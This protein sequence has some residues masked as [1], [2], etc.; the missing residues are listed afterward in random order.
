MG[1]LNADI[2]LA[3]YEMAVFRF[4]TI[5]AALCWWHGIHLKKPYSRNVDGSFHFCNIGDNLSIH[6]FVSEYIHGYCNDGLH[7]GN[8]FK[9]RWKTII[10]DVYDIDVH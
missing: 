7:I 1:G 9:A 6:I 5:D 10:H 4:N 3:L 8:D 2:Q